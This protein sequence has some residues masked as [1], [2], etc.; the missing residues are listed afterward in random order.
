M[1]DRKKSHRD[2]FRSLI[3]ALFSAWLFLGM[4]PTARAADADAAFESANRLL[5]LGKAGDASKAYEQIAAAGRTS[6]ALERNWAQACYQSGR[7]GPALAHLRR[8]TRLDPRDA[9]VRADLAVLRT[10]IGN[11]L[12]SSDDAAA[13]LRLLK[14]DEWAWLALGA[15]WIWFVM[16]GASRV[17][18]V[19]HAALR[20][21][22]TGSGAVAIVL[23][24]LLFAAVKQRAG[25]PDAVVL[26]PDTPV[27]QSPLDE[28]RATFAVPAAAEL[29]VRDTKG[30]WLMVEE[31]ATQRFGWLKQSE[32]LRIGF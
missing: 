24:A 32:V 2:R 21:F 6:P 14:L 1:N 7:P 25:E 23:S 11:G 5:A 22:T 4:A 12:G 18:P 19:A 16:L 13:A 30:G 3:G 28:A 26:A 10:K 29:R 17:S 15:V 20:G 27:R 31:T 8:A 9:D